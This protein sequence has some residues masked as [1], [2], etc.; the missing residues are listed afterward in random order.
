MRLAQE[1]SS[2]GFSERLGTRQ[3]T[4]QSIFETILTRKA[5]EGQAANQQASEA[6][7]HLGA[8]AFLHDTQ[9]AL[10]TYRRAVVLDPANV[11]GWGQ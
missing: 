6:A 7:R 10:T 11:E 3:L 1:G 4:L 5:S 2:Q 8:L 9:K